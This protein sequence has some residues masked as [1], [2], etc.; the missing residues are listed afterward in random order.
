MLSVK[1]FFYL[2]MCEHSETRARE[3]ER[4]A[5]SRLGSLRRIDS[6]SFRF[7]EVERFKFKCP[8]H[9]TEMKSNTVGSNFIF[10]CYFIWFPLQMF[11][12][13]LTFDFV[14]WKCVRYASVVVLRTQC[15]D[16]YLLF[17]F[18]VSFVCSTASLLA[19]TKLITLFK[20]L[21][22]LFC[23]F[24]SFRFFCEWNELY[25]LTVTPPI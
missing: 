17:Y 13:Q 9:V 14:H 25:N 4:N 21:L 6:N 1:N 15:I 5:Y 19:A 7:I 16:I 22:N 23:V 2:L 10:F 12:A 20:Q 24:N 3:Q 11:I 8:V 18:S